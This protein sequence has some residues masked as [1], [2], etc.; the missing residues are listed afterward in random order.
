ML[1]NLLWKFTEKGWIA[2][3]IKG[4]HLIFSPG[5]NYNSRKDHF[6]SYYLLVNQQ[7]LGQNCEYIFSVSFLCVYS[8]TRPELKTSFVQGN[9]RISSR[10]PAWL[11]RGQESSRF[12]TV[13]HMENEK[14]WFEYKVLSRKEEKEATLLTELF[15]LPRHSWE[16]LAGFPQTGLL[17]GMVS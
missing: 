2:P 10:L 7:P 8:R 9:Y 3:R 6:S 17:S 4:W 1:T 13:V 12:I 15:T 11:L 16:T 5:K 14:W